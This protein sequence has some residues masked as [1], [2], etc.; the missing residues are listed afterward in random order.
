MFAA[1]RL[2]AVGLLLAFT[3]IIGKIGERTGRNTTNAVIWSLVVGVLAARFTY[4]VTHLE[5]YSRDWWSAFAF[6]QGGFSVWAGAVGTAAVLLIMIGFNRTSS[7]SVGALVVLALAWAGGSSLVR[8][9]PQ[10]LP[11][12]PT[13][14]TLDGRVIKAADLNGRP[15]VINLWATWCP[16][17]R[18]EL[19]MIAEVA[20][21][22]EVPILLVNQAESREQVRQHLA[23]A[24]IAGDAVAL[25]ENGALMQLLGGGA[26]PT[27]LFVN[28]KSQIVE[29]HL[30]EISRAALL[31]HIARLEME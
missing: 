13:L 7:L 28:A 9:K 25:D 19:P 18:R 29:T 1:D 8:P 17:C 14:A 6:W 24:G 15:Y 4:V 27:T 12:L 26:L 31:D 11:D 2:L 23:E 5:A 21:G 10:P 30:G 20:A 16:P 3:Y 22:S